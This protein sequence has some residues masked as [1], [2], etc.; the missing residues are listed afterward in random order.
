MQPMAQGAARQGTCTLQA[1]GAA[2]QGPYTLQ[3]AGA[4]RRGR[5]AWGMFRVRILSMG[6]VVLLL[7]SLSCISYRVRGIALATPKFSHFRV[8]GNTWHTRE[9]VLTRC[10]HVLTRC[11]HAGDLHGAGCGT[12]AR[13]GP[14]D[15]ARS[16][17]PCEHRVLALHALRTSFSRLLECLLVMSYLVSGSFAGGLHAWLCTC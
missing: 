1:A 2:H 14:R 5:G 10:S 16:A 4:A 7:A 13:W 8:F 15:A 11:S 3:A 6:C 12:N 9:R 17:H